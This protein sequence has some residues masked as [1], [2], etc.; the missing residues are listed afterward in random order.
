MKPWFKFYGPEYLSDPKMLSLSAIE[1]ALWITM[2]CLAS[3]SQE[4]GSIRYINEEKI[5]MLTGMSAQESIDNLGF[6]KK[7]VSLKMIEISGD[8]GDNVITVLNFQKKQ[9]SALSD[10]ERVKRFREKH[11]E[12]VLIE[13]AKRRA[14]RNNAQG[15]FTFEQWVE[16]VE[17]QGDKCVICKN[18]FSNE[19]PPTIDHIVPLSKGGSND[20]SN[21]QAL[22]GR[23]NSSKG[24]S[25]NGSND[26]DNRRKIRVE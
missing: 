20:I 8:N 6:L 10:Y 9:E 11:P 5:M 4:E 22:C 14:R 15:S 1:R 12:S 7:F 18:K 24:N 26:G 23:C 17:K 16:V 25:D 21:I 3:T 19:L 2:M 13:N